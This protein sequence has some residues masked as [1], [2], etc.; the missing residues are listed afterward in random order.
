MI[1]KDLA[2]TNYNMIEILSVLY[3]TILLT[4]GLYI[5]FYIIF[6]LILT[7]LLL[8]EYSVKYWMFRRY[9]YLSETQLRKINYGPFSKVINNKTKLMRNYV[10]IRDTWTYIHYNNYNNYIGWVPKDF[11]D[12][13]RWVYNNYY[14]NN[15]DIIQCLDEIIQG[16]TKEALISKTDE[17]IRLVNNRYINKIKIN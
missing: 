16:K 9:A 11:E 17:C 6:I 12:W 10:F 4:A 14:D 3:N 13:V 2:Q 1:F 5:I 7:L 15:I 8:K